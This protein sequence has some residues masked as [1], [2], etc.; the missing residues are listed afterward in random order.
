[1]KTPLAVLFIVVIGIAAFL[2]GRGKPGDPSSKEAPAVNTRTVSSQS[3]A[4][5]A[6]KSKPK[7]NTRTGPDVMTVEKA[8]K[9]TPEER[10][11]L[12]KKAA[13]LADP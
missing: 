3:A 7:P 6:A 5:P 4:P 12:L 8:S 13:M 9:L 2:M 1:M 11:A 10:I